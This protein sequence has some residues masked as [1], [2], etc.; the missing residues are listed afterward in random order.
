MTHVWVDRVS[1][2]SVA[3]PDEIREAMEEIFYSEQ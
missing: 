3:I 2:E 1:R